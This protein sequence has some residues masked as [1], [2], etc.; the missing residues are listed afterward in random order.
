MIRLGLAACMAASTAFLR[1]MLLVLVIAEP[2][3]SKSRRVAPYLLTTASYCA[4]SLLLVL[5]SRASSLPAAPPKEITASP[6]AAR[7][8]LMN[9]A[10]VLSA[11][12]APTPPHPA[13]QLV[14]LSITKANVT[15]L[16]PA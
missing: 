4:C 7:S 14:L 13:W 12:T 9:P 11:E 8:L 1:L 15:Y 2:S 6:P 3:T 10:K 16:R 5:Q